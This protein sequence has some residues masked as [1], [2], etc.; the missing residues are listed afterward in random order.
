M[1]SMFL[2]V[3]RWCISTKWL[4][5]KSKAKTTAWYEY[6]HKGWVPGY[7]SSARYHEDIDT[8]VIQFVSTTGG[9]T[10]GDSG[11]NRRK[12]HRLI[13]YR[14]WPDCRDTARAIEFD[15]IEVS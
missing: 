12:G 9:D 14:I 4:I 3:K 8:V 2:S 7:F 11:C 13:E 15:S 10:W 5:S 1:G 6:E